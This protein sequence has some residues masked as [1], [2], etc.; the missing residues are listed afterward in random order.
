MNI[1]LR[2]FDEIG[3]E[4]AE[5]F[6]WSGAFSFL[7][8]KL[9]FTAIVATIVIIFALIVLVETL[10]AG[11]VQL[12]T[13]EFWLPITIVIAASIRSILDK[14]TG[15]TGWKTTG[16]SSRIFLTEAQATIRVL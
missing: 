15:L 13:L 12:R 1:S 6:I 14:S 7:L 4:M 10:E 11:V 8:E 2:L 9:L 16:T 5:F 3:E